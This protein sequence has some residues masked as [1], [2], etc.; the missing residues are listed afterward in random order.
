MVKL[1]TQHHKS[2]FDGE[3][4]V[5]LYGPLTPGIVGVA[6]QHQVALPFTDHTPALHAITPGPTGPTLGA[7]FASNEEV[8]PG[9]PRPVVTALTV[10]KYAASWMD[11]AGVTLVDGVA[12]AGHR[13][14]H[15]SPL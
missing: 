12:T 15:L 8:V 6:L 7:V 11:D 1:Q 5:H 13:V 2:E 9:A 3:W 10:L 4:P 14:A